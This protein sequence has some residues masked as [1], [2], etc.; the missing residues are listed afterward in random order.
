LVTFWLFNLT[1]TAIHS[2]EKEKNKKG[3][4]GGKKGGKKKIFLNSSA[5]LDL[6]W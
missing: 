1:A 5:R 3:K 2:A 4:T 6:L